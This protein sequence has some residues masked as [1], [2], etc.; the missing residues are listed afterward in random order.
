[1]EV[2]VCNEHENMH[3]IQIALFSHKTWNFSLVMGTSTASSWYRW[4]THAHTRHLVAV[5]CTTQV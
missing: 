2:I 1:M 5:A 3:Q 4:D